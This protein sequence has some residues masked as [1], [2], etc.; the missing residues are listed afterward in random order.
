[1]ALTACNP[2]VAESN[3]K[4]APEIA[5]EIISE[6]QNC[7]IPAE[8][9]FDNRIFQDLNG[10]RILLFYSYTKTVEDALIL[11]NQIDPNGQAVRYGNGTEL[12]CLVNGEGPYNCSGNSY[13]LTFP[14]QQEIDDFAA[15]CLDTEHENQLSLR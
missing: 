15:R 4:T 13:L 10:N 1:M 11:A 3:L 9:E 7:Q 14:T 5:P 8:I 2:N 6:T 12:P